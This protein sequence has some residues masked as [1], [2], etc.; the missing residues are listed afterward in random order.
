MTAPAMAAYWRAQDAAA[1]YDM[2]P[3]YM[4]AVLAALVDADTW[5]RALLLAAQCDADI[6]GCGSAAVS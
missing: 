1:A 5:D 2:F 3:R 4:V 6:H